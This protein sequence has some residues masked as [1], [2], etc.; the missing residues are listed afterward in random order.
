VKSDEQAIRDLVAEWMA[1]SRRGDTSRVLEL[2]AD[3]VVFLTVGAP[4]FGKK[5]F[6]AMSH[7]MTGFK[8][9]G[10]S[11]IQEIQVLGNWAWMRNHLKVSIAGPDGKTV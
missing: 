8:I 7:Q 1:A 5:E 4:P 3:D 9:D 2:M 11:D 10:S 6:E